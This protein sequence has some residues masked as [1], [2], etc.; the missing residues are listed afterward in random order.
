MQ[1]LEIPE[2]HCYRCGNTW[3][4]RGRVIRICPRCKSKYWDEPKIAV[5]RF[6][7]GVGIR[8]VLGPHKHQIEEIAIR[9]DIRNIRVFGSVARKAATA[10]SDVD[11]LVDFGRASRSKSALRCFDFAAELEALLHRRVEVVTESSLHWW[12]QPQVIAEAIPL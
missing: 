6:G 8:E 5:P 7:G 9:F 10:E 4:P 2:L 11:L 1:E 3:T 12:I